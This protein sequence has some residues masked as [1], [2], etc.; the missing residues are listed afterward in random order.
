MSCCLHMW[1]VNSRYYKCLP[2]HPANHIQL[3]NR[4]WISATHLCV[5]VHSNWIPI[6]LTNLPENL[7]RCVYSYTV[8]QVTS[9]LVE[10]L[11]WDLD[12]LF[13]CGRLFPL[14]GHRHRI[15]FPEVVS[16]VSWVFPT[17]SFCTPGAPAMRRVLL[18]SSWGCHRTGSEG[19]LSQKWEW[20]EAAQVKPSVNP[21]KGRLSSWSKRGPS[22]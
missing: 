4:Y 12:F 3:Q 9:W 8:A 13:P 19:S 21:T 11:D 6:V 10:E 22:L 7:A 20:W 5:L 15:M 2:Y 17:V 18:V 14:P 1:D 16:W